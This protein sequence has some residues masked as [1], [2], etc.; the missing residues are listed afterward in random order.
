MIKKGFTLQEL[1]ITLGIVGV[2]S[3][4]TI[5][6]IMSV[7]PDKNKSLFIKTY[8]TIASLT[9][10]ILNDTS[11]YLETYDTDGKPNCVGMG[12]TAR[13]SDPQYNS[14]SYEGAHKF[15]YLLADK[16]DLD[17]D[18]TRTFDG[19]QP[20]VMDFRTTGGTTW[21]VISTCMNNTD[22]QMECRVVQL[23]VDVNPN[24]SDCHNIYSANCTN[25]TRF[26]LTID[27]NGKLQAA[28]A[29]SIAYL[30]NPTD[31]HAKDK[32][33]KLAEQLLAAGST[34]DEM[35]KA[36]EKINKDK[37]TKKTS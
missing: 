10:E 36:L 37:K 1:L 29:M 20:N 33:R 19:V 12:C 8:R 3:A 15:A 5:P 24:S 28:D 35:Y 23:Q 4:I 21:H 2:I 18:V 17:G 7:C 11:L 27:A 32:D 13:P 31:L 16:L 14:E 30:Q 26:N 9:N 6:A 22:G 34:S 25:P